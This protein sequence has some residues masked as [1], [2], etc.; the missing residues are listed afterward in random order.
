MNATTSRRH[1][2]GTRYKRKTTIKLI[3][4]NRKPNAGSVRRIVRWTSNV[5]V[6]HVKHQSRGK[7]DW[8][9]IQR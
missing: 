6:R 3:E 9:R 4:I 2:Q 8:S 1:E 5:I 7:I